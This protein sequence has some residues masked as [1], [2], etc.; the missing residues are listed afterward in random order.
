MKE[1]I[2]KVQS[3]NDIITNSSTEIITTIS[4]DAVDIIKNLVD[5][6]LSISKSRY[7][8][9]SLFTIETHWANEDGWNDYGYDSK[10][11]YI[12]DLE[13]HNGDL[14][15]CASGKSYKVTAIDP[16]NN[17]AAELLNKLQSIVE[18]FESYC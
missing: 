5:E 17:T 9:D 13:E 1:I 12:Q 7:C 4:S 10:E 11:A 14:G 2:I 18:S 8:F 15:S 3:L 6:L 16:K